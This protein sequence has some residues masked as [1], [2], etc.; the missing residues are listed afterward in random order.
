ML[1]PLQI[2]L[3]H[4]DELIAR[5]QFAEAARVLIELDQQFPDQVEVLSRLMNLAVA[6]D[7]LSA[8]LRAVEPLARLRPNDPEIALNLAVAWLKMRHLAL[9]QQSFA[10]FAE[11]WPSHPKAADAHQQAHELST[12]LGVLWREY[13]LADPPDLVLM[14][15]NEEM[16]N[17]VS[18]GAFQEAVQLAEQ[19]LRRHPDFIAMRNNLSLAYQNLG[20]ID[21]A[22]AAT[23]DVLTRDP[24]NLHALG[25]MTRFLVLAGKLDQ[26]T[27]LAEQLKSVPTTS[28]DI[29]LK[30]AEAL[31]FFGDDEGVLVAF[32]HVQKLKDRDDD[33]FASAMLHHLAAVASMRQGRIQAARRRWQKALDLHP[34]LELAAANLADLKLPEDKRHAPW[35]YGIAYWLQ[36]SIIEE[37]M[38]EISARK[39]RSDAALSQIAQ[40]FL[41][42]HPALKTLVPLLLDRGDPAARQFA[43]RLADMARTPELLNALADFALSQRGPTDDRMHA[44]QLAQQSGVIANGMVRFWQSGAWH[45]TM[46][47]G[48]ELHG[49]PIVH[50]LSPAI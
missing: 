41:Q 40:R 22:I 20:K 8:I 16:Q 17:L 46:M 15:R 5:E 34:G 37:L 31:S 1:N 2:G 29:A 25:N 33:T 28:I 42:R 7:D 14:A 45:E 36:R 21:E 48:I 47:L 39:P 13:G 24:H 49:E 3:T 4:A 11:R 27:L 12:M 23:Q 44:A 10:S 30:Q 32:E 18:R 43:L 19:A 38:R 9:A 35:P 6:V 26:A 50:G